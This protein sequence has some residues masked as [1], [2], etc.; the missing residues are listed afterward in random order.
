MSVLAIVM[1]TQAIARTIEFAHDLLGPQRDDAT[2]ARGDGG[3]AAVDDGGVRQS[4]VV[5]RGGAACA[6]IARRCPRDGGELS[7]GAARR[8]DLH[9]RGNRGEQPRDLRAVR[10]TAGGALLDRHGASLR[11]RTAETT[12]EQRIFRDVV[13]RECPWDCGHV[14]GS[15]Y[16][17]PDLLATGE[18]RDGCDPTGSCV[19]E[20]WGARS[21]R[22]GTGR[23]ENPRIVSLA[24]C[25]CH[26]ALGT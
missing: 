17:T 26:V 24:R 7:G 6:A 25:H 5:A 23:G 13:A 10:R 15:T 2:F 9:Q 12:C 21:L 4:V 16:G 19:R 18:P 1:Q 8:S 11:R 3:D 22:C 20:P 14:S